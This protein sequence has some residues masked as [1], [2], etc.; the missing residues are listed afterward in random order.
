VSESSSTDGECKVDVLGRR[1][2]AEWIRYWIEIAEDIQAN[3]R[4]IVSLQVHEQD[5]GPDGTQPAPGP[6]GA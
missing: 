5:L 2:R 6:G 1:S 3:L 4:V